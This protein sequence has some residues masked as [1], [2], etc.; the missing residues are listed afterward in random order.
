M[1]RT[2]ENCGTIIR[3]HYAPMQAILRRSATTGYTSKFCSEQCANQ[4][5]ARGSSPPVA[6]G[7]PPD[8]HT[9]AKPAR[10]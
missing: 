7:A 6:R 4:W 3:G 9:P 2:C 1:S 10:G 5:V 8:N